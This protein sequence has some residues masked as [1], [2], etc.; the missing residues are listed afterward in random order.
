[1][2]KQQLY[3]KDEKGKYKPY[4]EPERYNALCR[5]I[6][7][8]YEPVKMTLGDYYSE[9]EWDEGVF[10]ITRN[11]GFESWISA[12]YLRKVFSLYKCGDIEKV[13]IAKLGGM[14]KIADYLASH[15]DE[16]PKGNATIYDLAHNI[17]AIIMNLE[18]EKEE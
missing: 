1:M 11:H 5:K 14:A 17:V 6:G 4:K 8:R 13:S 12:G 10:A 9:K 3:F 2:K 15:W 18:N 16:L 7:N